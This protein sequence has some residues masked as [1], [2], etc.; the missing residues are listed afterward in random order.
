MIS[1]KKLSTIKLYVSLRSKSLVLV[2]FL[3]EFAWTIWKI[4]N[5]KYNNCKGIDDILNKFRFILRTES[6]IYK[7]PI[8]RGQIF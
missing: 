3:F 5:L 8:K 2:I 1:V 6:P 7:N 4:C